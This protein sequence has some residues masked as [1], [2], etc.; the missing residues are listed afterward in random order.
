MRRTDVVDVLARLRTD[1]AVVVGP[2][3]ASG[4]LCAARHRPATIYNMELGYASAVC[5]GLAL[6]DP[7]LAVV[8]VE[9]DGSMLAG[10]GVLTTIARYRPANLTVVV[11]D[12][13]RY[14]TC[15]SG[16][17]ESATAGATDLAAV[18]RGCGLDPDRVREV[19]DV[20]ATRRALED[21]FGSP[22]PWFVVAAVSD[23]DRWPDGRGPVPD[24]DVV[25]T[26][27]AMRR[28]LADRRRAG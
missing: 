13:G 20:D 15:G 12:N 22:G 3:S 1:Q 18:A 27:A 14:A 2:G 25:E 19:S 8:A 16:R 9:G 26:A 11:L 10:L 17:F 28:E 4:A 24:H 5:L 21:A 7:R 6:A 23:P